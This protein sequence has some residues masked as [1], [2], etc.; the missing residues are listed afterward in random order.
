M[1]VRVSGEIVAALTVMK[2]LCM[3]EGLFFDLKS[4]EDAWG[5]ERKE[6]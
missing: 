4:I 5:I 2:S 3:H 6:L 1:E